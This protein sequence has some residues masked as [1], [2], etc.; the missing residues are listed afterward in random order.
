MK[1]RMKNAL[2]FAHE[3][4]P[5]N[6]PESTVGAQRPAQFAKYLP[7]FGW[8]AIVLCC[9]HER[10]GS[11]DK[12]DLT[13]IAENARRLLRRADP[14]ASIII[15]TPSLRWD[16]SLDHL[17]RATADAKGGLK[18]IARKSLTT[19]KFFTGD[20]SQNWQPC[21]R[22]A[23]EAIAEE[24]NIDAC[25]G[26]HGPDA[27]IF[28][29]RWFSKK[30]KTPWVADFR[31]P[32]LQPLTP[33]ARKFYRPVARRLLLSASATINVNRIWAEMD[34]K[35]F[36]L[37]SRSIPNGFD[38]DEFESDFETH[39]SDRFTI[40]YTGNIISQQRVEIF[41]EGLALLRAQDEEAFQNARFVYRG[42]AR[43]KV[44]GMAERFGV[45]EIAD[46]GAR[47]ERDATLGLLRSAS[48]L[49]LLSIAQSEK[50]DVYYSK[51]LYPAKVFEY[52]GA[53]RPIICVPGDNG[54][55][56]ELIKKT[57]T[58]VLL[59]SPREVADYLS[60]V[61]RQ[62]KSGCEI[63]HKPD[64]KEVNRYTRRN[65]AG[66]LAEVLNTVTASMIADPSPTKEAADLSYT[67]GRDI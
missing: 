9:D 5:H 62:W 44:A 17:W 66:Q 38:T 28:L 35:T 25:I 55:L 12:S 49:L 51:G 58:G 16:G 18:K 50:E 2:I 65:L 13:G 45:E 26:E 39:H 21:A 48:L 56:D 15:P 23:A 52:F 57:A 34:Q 27:G 19:A 33:F 30:Y 37:P 6:R 43:E 42:L 64:E 8:R 29:G 36:G 20:Y 24:T 32:I 11:A 59:R 41:I 40:L 3:C 63:F 4:A 22:A 7:D 54:L 61:I 67:T 14:R 60:V 53:R 46:I 47:I 1:E 10:R 31:D